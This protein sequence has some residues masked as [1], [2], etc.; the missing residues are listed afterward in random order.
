VV[1]QSKIRRKRR[2]NIALSPGV[3]MKNVGGGNLEMASI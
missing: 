1:K 2:T 3:R